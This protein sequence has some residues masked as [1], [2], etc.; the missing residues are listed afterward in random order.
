EELKSIISACLPVDYKPDIIISYE[1]PAPFFKE[2]FPSSLLLN[3]M[4]G[5]FSR[6]PFPAYGLLDPCGLYEYSYQYKY[7]D[8]IRAEEISEEEKEVIKLLR[9]QSSRALAAYHPLKKY[10][11]SLYEKYDRLIV[12]ACQVD[13][14]FSYNS[15]TN[16]PSQYAMV[17]DVLSQVPSNIGVI[18]TEHGYKRQISDEQIESLNEKYSNFIYFSKK[19]VFTPSQF[20]LPYVDGALSVSSSIGYQAA[21]W[22]IPYFGLGKSQVDVLCSN[23]SLMSF[24]NDVEK[25]IKIDRDNILYVLLSKVHLSHK[26]DLFNGKSYLNKLKDLFNKFTSNC[27][28]YEYFNTKKSIDEV[29]KDIIC[30]NREWLLKKNFI[31]SKLVPEVDHLRVAMSHSKAISYDLFDTL[32]ERDFVEPHELFNLIESR[33]RNEL[34]NKNFP[35]YYVRR[36]AEID[37]RRETR[38]EFEI[39]LDEIYERF[40]RYFD[41]TLEQLEKIKNIEIDAEVELVH[42]KKEMVRE[43]Y[44]SQMICESVSIITDIYLSQN[45]IERILQKVK[46]SGYN[47]LLVSAETKT[48]KHNG[49]IYP[50]YLKYIRD[51]FDINAGQALHVGDNKQADGD[52]AKKHGIKTYVFQKAIDNYKKSLIA[53]VL[54]SSINHPGISSSVINGLFANKYHAGHWFK[55]NKESI[56]NAD[57]YNYGYMAIGPLVVGFTQWL[58]RRVNKLG[59][60]K[61]YF[62]SRD[63][64]ILKKTFDYFYPESSSGIKTEYLYS[65]R[66]TAMVA[67][68][69]NIDDI[70]EVASQNFNAR[71]LSDFLSARFGLDVDTVKKSVLEKYNYKHDTIVSPYFEFGKL[72]GFL[73]DIHHTIL[74]NAKNERESYIDYLRETGFENDCLNGGATVVDIGYSGSMQ[75][76]LKKILQ[77]PCV[78]GFYFLTHHHSRDYFSNDHFEGFLQNLDDHKIAYRHGLNDHVFIFVA[79]LSSPEGSL[80]KMEGK[81]Q[82]REMIF[83]EAEEEIVRKNALLGTHRG[84][85]DF[86]HDIKTRFGSYFKYIEFSPILSSQLI[87]NFANNP[88]GIDAGM[89]ASHE[90]ENVFGGGSVCLISPLLDCYKDSNGTINPK[91]IDELL[92]ASKWKR[93]ASAYYNLVNG[94]QPRVNPAKM[95][96]PSVNPVVVKQTPQTTY[97]HPLKTTTQRKLAKLKKDPY[98][99]FNDSQKPLLKSLRL[100]FKNTSKL[101]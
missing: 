22:Q 100:F 42:P 61:L 77:C 53:D 75:Y 91:I 15:C 58:Y 32:V 8:K 1:S 46:I 64:W 73:K 74:S 38:G 19:D 12:L 30:G 28:E 27:D 87:L 94:T 71:K 3:A 54:R 66:R 81:G 4:F 24:V 101:N 13:N 55:I 67:S 52:M 7:A 97:A 70:I 16:Y 89:F 29:R 40:P 79:A 39:T 83:L 82:E 56:F 95:P 80:I 33:V 37:L 5:I 31:D 44:F 34:N 60:K 98:L 20:I 45:V 84:V 65:S 36:Q 69:R 49:T 11:S 9:R 57:E 88:N 50:E 72:I 76:Y 62:L 92:K 10:I 51:N 6:A 93:G 23:T 78:N 14:Y 68:L 2:I 90:V 99:F 17:E 21:L 47:K 18:V 48:R 85:M 63:G 26:N 25:G 59:I 41:L 43:F 96:A 35:F 86:V